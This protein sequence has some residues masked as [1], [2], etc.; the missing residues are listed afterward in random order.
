[1]GK[2]QTLSGIFEKKADI[3]ETLNSLKEKVKI[4]SGAYKGVLYNEIEKDI[5]KIIIDISEHIENR[6]ITHEIMIQ[7]EKHLIILEN[8]ATKE[9]SFRKTNCG[10]PNRDDKK[11][12]KMRK[13]LENIGNEFETLSTND[14]DSFTHLKS[15]LDLVT[16]ELDQLKN[17][18]KNEQQMKIFIQNEIEALR[19]TVDAKIYTAKEGR[20]HLIL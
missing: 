10:S 7:A 20:S 8:R 19:I 1:M 13:E 11:L 17:L 18:N 2:L 12:V 16:L 15:R 4:F 9:Q 14:V 5:N 3:T 6:E